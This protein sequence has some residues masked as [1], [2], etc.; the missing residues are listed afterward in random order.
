MN[1]NDKHDEPER[2]NHLATP[3]FLATLKICVDCGGRLR[4]GHRYRCRRCAEAAAQEAADALA[5]DRMRRA[6]RADSCE[7]HL[8][9]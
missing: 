4:P 9:G 1:W 3:E 8:A 7:R 5:I 6:A 2:A